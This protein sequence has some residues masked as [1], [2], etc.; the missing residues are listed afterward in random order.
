MIGI[1]LASRHPKN[2]IVASRNFYGMLKVEQVHKPAES[3]APMLE[4]AHGR[5]AHGAQFLQADMRSIPTAYYANG[6]G[7]GKLMQSS[8]EAPRR[9][10][11][12]G[13]G[14]GTLAAYARPGDYFRM[15]EINPDVI[16]IAKRYF[17]YLSDSV[18]EQSIVTGDARLSLEFEP[19]QNFDI[20]VIDA[21]SGDAIPVHLLTKE[22]IEVY[23]K[24][25][26][27]DGI[28]AFHISNLHFNL[29]PV[30]AGLAKDQGFDYRFIGSPP[31]INTAARP[32]V[33]AFV[34]RRPE[35]LASAFKSPD[36]NGETAQESVGRPITWTDARSNLLEVIW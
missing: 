7:I 10:G 35:T 14:V 29:R 11:I 26:K 30:I 15:Y 21:F 33:W 20:L 3:I 36:R 12:V 24:H 22:A 34:S 2:S 27:A 4:L 13:L 17:T 23:L 19:S 25:L 9:I 32:A 5:I 1:A 16:S 18:A 31:D 28:L 8:S 6:T